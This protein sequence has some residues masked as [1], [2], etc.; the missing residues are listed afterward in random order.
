MISITLQKV[1]MRV[2]D[3][4]HLCTLRLRNSRAAVDG[5]HSTMVLHPLIVGIGGTDV[6]DS[7]MQPFPVL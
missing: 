4:V 6:D 2:L 5:L 1:Y 7:A 3:A